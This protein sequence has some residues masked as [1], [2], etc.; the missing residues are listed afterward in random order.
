MPGAEEFENVELNELSTI[1]KQP[2]TPFQTDFLSDEYLI[3]VEDGGDDI[4][5]LRQHPLHIRSS[6]TVLGGSSKDILGVSLLAA[7]GTAV[8]TGA[9]FAALSSTTAAATAVGIGATTSTANTVT[10][11]GSLTAKIVTALG[12]APGTGATAVVYKVVQTLDDHLPGAAEMILNSVESGKIDVSEEN[13]TN[14]LTLIMSNTSLLAQLKAAGIDVTLL[15]NGSI[16]KIGPAIAKALGW[17]NDIESLAMYSP[18]VT[19]KLNQT[20]PLLR[21]LNSD[22]INDIW[23]AATIA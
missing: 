14:W 19:K 2:V 13:V 12:A 7:T 10:A 9:T 22:F 23:R 8:A 15:S 18:D 1:P 20:S 3:E 4:L 5:F 6:F 16:A 17:K 11:V 21:N